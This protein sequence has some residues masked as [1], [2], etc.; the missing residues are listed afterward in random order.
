MGKIALFAGTFDPITLGHED[1][2]QRAAKM[3]DKLDRKS[4]V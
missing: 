3:F 4:V 1:I 2:A